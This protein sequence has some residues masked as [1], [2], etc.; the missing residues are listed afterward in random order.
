[1]RILSEP[2]R[3]RGATIIAAIS[4]V[5]FVG[6][7]GVWS[8]GVSMNRFARDNQSR[9][10]ANL[11]TRSVHGNIEQLRL[12]SS[13]RELPEKIQSIETPQALEWLDREIGAVHA[14]DYD[15]RSVGIIGPKGAIYT[16]EP[17]GRH[18]LDGLNQLEAQTELVVGL[19]RSGTAHDLVEHDAS[20]PEI[21]AK[22]DDTNGRKLSRWDIHIVEVNRSPAIVGAARIGDAGTGNILVTVTPISPFRI[23]MIGRTLMLEDLKGIDV[24][25]PTPGG[26]AE[27]VIH[28][29][30]GKP[31][32]KLVWRPQTPGNALLYG[33][34]PAMFAMVVIFI[35][36]FAIAVRRLHVLNEHAVKNSRKA[37]YLANFDPLSGLANRRNFGEYLDKLVGRRPCQIAFVDLDDF[38]LIN[39]TMGHSAGDEIVKTIADR[40]TA[41]FS[42]DDYRVARLGGDEFAIVDSSPE[43]DADRFGERIMQL[44]CEKVQVDKIALSMSLSAG[45]AQSPEFGTTVS[46]LMRNADIALYAAKAE[47]KGAYAIYSHKLGHLVEQRREREELLAGAIENG[48]FELHY[49]PIVCL[50]TDLPTSIEALVRLKRNPNLTPDV[51]I[52][53]VENMGLMP[54]LGEWIIKAAFE[55]SL[56]WPGVHTSIN[57]SPLQIQSADLLGIVDGYKAEFDID[58]ATIIFEITEGVLLD[59]TQHV[60]SV[61]DGL[62]GRGYKLAL[63]DFGTGYSSL[64]YLGDM[65]IDRLKLDQSFVRGGRIREARNATLVKAVIDI[66]RNLGIEVV[67]EGVEDLAEVEALRLWGCSHVQG[68]LLSKAVPA[69]AAVKRLRDLMDKAR[70]SELPR[71]RTRKLT[72]I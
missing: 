59:K 12:S 49:Q 60:R 5:S 51:F 71:D 41:T 72:V 1:M 37:L 63:D 22:Y 45:I 4:A 52:P 9:L 24:L 55:D 47:G 18:S 54:R 28:A 8:A 58:P 64:S 65:N 30:D 66:G 46:E 57:L 25:S 23:E 42:G 35:A 50:A 34:L 70:N 19:L 40:L 33:I 39:D 17:F 53:I 3:S 44:I 29:D 62:K 21:E 11:I 6:M 56:K 7:A 36:L 69:T 61:L 48:A 67:A 43:R 2:K 16:F 13:K 26:Y 15:Q 38:K 14:E 20:Y 68:Y 32:S 31:I 10:I 27:F